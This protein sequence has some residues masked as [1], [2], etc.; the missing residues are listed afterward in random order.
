MLSTKILIV[1][2][3][4]IIALD[5]KRRL[6][7]MGFQ[8][9]GIADCAEIALLLVSHHQSDLVLMDIQLQTEIDGIQAANQIQ[10]EFNVPVIFVTAH[11]ETTSC[12]RHG[13]LIRLVTLLN[14][15]RMLIY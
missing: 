15:S 13:L 10:A 14:R 2:D 4:P 5:L 9:A 12:N 1:E 11:S 6:I 7:R 8:V 3:E